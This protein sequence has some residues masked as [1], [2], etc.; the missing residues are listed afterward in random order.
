MPG[1]ITKEAF[2]QTKDGKDVTKF[3]LKNSS[4]NLVVRLLDY[5]ALISEINVP[6]RNGKVVDITLGFD[7]LPGYEADS[8]FSGAIVG[9]VAGRI[10]GGQFTL[11]GKTYDLCVNS[12]PN[13]LHGGKVGF[14]KKVW[15]G[16]V[17][18]DKVVLTYVSPDGEE[19][20]PGELTT[21]VSYRVTDDNE[22]ILEYEATTTKPTPV[23]LT[24][25]AYFNLAG[26]NGGALD[27]HVVTIP[28]DTFLPLDETNI[29]IGEIK[30]VEGTEWDLRKPTRLGDRQ[31]QVPGGNGFD[32]TYCLPPSDGKPQLAAKLEHPPS[33]RTIECRT[34][35]P[36]MHLYTGFFLDVPH[37]KGGATYKQYGAMCLEAQHY[38]DSVH[39]PSWPTT[40]LRPGETYRQKTIY[41]FGVA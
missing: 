17:E 1:E 39:H 6:D 11:D 16:K 27:E 21:T 26:H 3:T 41:K 31:R 2:G 23:N 18:G 15:S 30:K 36:G 13:S 34:T 10:A 19:G 4:G 37:G 22:L 14:Y 32:H 24:N 29:P 25:H 20:Y 8:L 7:D 35:E 12:P 9:R 40:I 28:T 5:G 33:G 38:P